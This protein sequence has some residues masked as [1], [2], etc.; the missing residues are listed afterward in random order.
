MD[1]Q[2]RRLLW[3]TA[4][5]AGL[6]IARAARA[7]AYPAKPVRVIVPFAAGG[8]TDVFA[9]LIAL[10]LSRALG[11][12]FYVENQPGAGGNLGMGA[13]ARAAPDGHALTVVSTSFVVNPSLYTKIPYNPTKDFAP[14]TPPATSP[15]WLV[16]NPSIPAP[17]A[18]ELF[19]FLRSNPGK[20][21][22]AHPGVG[23]TS[24]LGGEMFKPSQD[25]DLVSVPFN[26]SAPAVQS[27]LAGHT[28]I[29]F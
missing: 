15:N 3:L 21:S 10:S 17:P 4:C 11:Q 23:T 29:A 24:Q 19:S 27:V 5:A 7:Q 2:R 25:L 13:G 6:P 28:P 8:P 26:G 9:R 1:F 12:Q 20:Y 18:N 22:I 14:V 16:I